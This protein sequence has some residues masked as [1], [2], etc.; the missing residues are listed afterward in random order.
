[1]SK[2]ACFP[3]ERRHTPRSSNRRYGSSSICA[4]FILPFLATGDP[5]HAI[6]GRSTDIAL[7]KNGRTLVNVNSHAHS[8]T[9]FVVRGNGLVKV[10]EIPVGR[11][12]H[13]VAV[14]KDAEAYVTNSASGTVSVIRLNSAKKYRV[15][16]EIPVGTEPRG[17]ALSPSGN[18]LYVANYTQSSVSI[19][20]TRSKQVVTT[21]PLPVSAGN[22]PPNPMAIAVTDNG[23][24]KDRDE[25]VFVTQF[26][27]ELRPGGPG[28]A[29]DDGKQG[30]V[31][32]FPVNDPGAVSRIILS[33]LA[34]SGF[35]ADRTNFC[36]KLNPAA[37]NDT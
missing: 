4:S 18:L 28:E 21:V 20:D 6:P 12:P 10:A 3:F 34:D 16:R 11:E 17:C 25:T 14:R 33:P 22:P 31:F 35:A 2:F 36:K 26:L 5:A 9:V 15:I 8:V 23:N 32:A 7:A 27:A 24:G 1:M 29:F 37:A 19:I 13:C 30:V